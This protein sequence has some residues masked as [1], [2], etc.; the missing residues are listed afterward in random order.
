MQS[1]P[2]LL[3]VSYPRSGAH[4]IRAL[5][6]TCTN[7]FS[8][9]TKIFPDRTDGTCIGLHT[10]DLNYMHYSSLKHG[11]QTVYTHLLVIV[12][13]PLDVLFSQC[14]Y[15][16]YNWWSERWKGMVERTM[17]E[18]QDH[19]QKYTTTTFTIP[20]LILH[21]QDLVDTPAQAITKLC[22]FL[23][24]TQPSQEKMESG[25]AFCNKDNMRAAVK[26]DPKA[27]SPDTSQYNNKRAQ[28]KK[29]FAY[30]MK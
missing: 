10:H 1:K 19:Q 24:L 2:N 20:T 16:N 30:L 14:E 23:G 4:L 6:E 18:I 11:Q 12:R 28:F 13:D 27:I 8:K 17:A 21:Y 22:D 3:S 15:Y 25:I 29:R 7:R 5:L 26:H 9:T